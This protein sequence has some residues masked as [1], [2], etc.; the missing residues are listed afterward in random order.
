MTQAESGER[1]AHVRF[2]PPFV[3]QAFI[4]WAWACG[5]GWRHCE[6]LHT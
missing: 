6:F 4:L 2:P 3:Y 5:T 1:G